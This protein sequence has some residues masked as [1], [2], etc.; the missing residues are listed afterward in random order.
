M[1]KF[2][3]LISILLTAV[4]ISNTANAA[5][6]KVSRSVWTEQDEKAYSDFVERICDSK[7]GNLNKFIRDPKVN[8]FYGE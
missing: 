7:Y 4:F 6:W 2:L 5:A 8:P 1:K 3:I